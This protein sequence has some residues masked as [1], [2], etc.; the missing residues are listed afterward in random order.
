M[1]GPGPQAL[2]PGQRRRLIARGV[3][4][5]LASTTVLVALYFLVPFALI[6]ALPLVVWLVVAFLVLVA[7]SAWQ[8]RAI[9]RSTH[10]TVQAIVALAITAPLYLL[11]FAVTYFL[12]SVSGSEHFSTGVLTRLDALYFTVTIFATVGFGDISPAT[13]G[14]RLIVMIQ[15]ILN[16]LVLGAGIKVFVGAVQRRRKDQES[17]ANAVADGTP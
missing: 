16:L 11:L 9:A 4:R 6:S 2:A 12:L 5:A 3:L 17:D 14:A 1:T 13:Q 8:L 10:P 15:M 7:V